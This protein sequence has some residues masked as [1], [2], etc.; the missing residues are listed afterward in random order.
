[1]I[2]ALVMISVLNGIEVSWPVAEMQQMESCQS[3]MQMIE[4]GGHGTG[5]PEGAKMECR[6]FEKTVMY[7]HT[8]ARKE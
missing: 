2:V 3:L 6:Q 8:G 7:E 1:M 5:Y 4:Q